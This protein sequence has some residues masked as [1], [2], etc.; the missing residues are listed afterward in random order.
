MAVADEPEIDDPLTPSDVTANVFIEDQPQDQ[1]PG[2]ALRQGLV[3][4]KL[5]PLQ[6]S[7][8]G[9]QGAQLRLSGVLG[10]R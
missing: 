10:R 1:L 3:A 4:N 5:Q 7:T 8:L 2:L 6:L 9:T